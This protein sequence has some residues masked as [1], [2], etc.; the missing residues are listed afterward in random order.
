VLALAAG[1]GVVVAG[2]RRPGGR[3]G[4]VVVVLGVPPRPAR[5]ARGFA[6][7]GAARLVVLRRP[8][9][10][11]LPLG[12]EP[13]GVL[14]QRVVGQGALRRTFTPVHRAYLTPA[15]GAGAGVCRPAALLNSA[16]TFGWSAKLI[17]ARFP[18]SVYAL[19]SCKKWRSMIN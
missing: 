6:L 17:G 10:G 15:Q 2:A 5:L 4:L 9:R 1:P 18:A 16:I 14:E 12:G 13:R 19:L 8:C 11:L 3:S 7:R